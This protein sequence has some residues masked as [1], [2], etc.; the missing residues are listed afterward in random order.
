MLFPPASLVSGGGQDTGPV[1]AASTAP[2]LW[3]ALRKDPYAGDE[4]PIRCRQTASFWHRSVETPCTS[5]STD[6]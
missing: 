3:A 4:D 2:G 5:R 1:K 6:S